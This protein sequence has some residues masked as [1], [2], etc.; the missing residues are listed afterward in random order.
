MM[1][2]RETAADGVY[3]MIL[4]NLLCFASVPVFIFGEAARKVAGINYHNPITE[5][6]HDIFSN[7][8]EYDTISGNIINQIADHFAQFLLVKKINIDY[9]N[10]T[11]YQY[12]YSK[13]TKETFTDDFTNIAWENLEDESK[14]VMTNSYIFMIKFLLV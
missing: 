9:K 8:T 3:R 14:D 5:S 13:F 1:D 12:N 4:Y 11:F 2:H 10:T 7:I 6:C